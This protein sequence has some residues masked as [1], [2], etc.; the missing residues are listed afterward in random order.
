MKRSLKFGMG[1]LSCAIAA[2]VYAAT[3]LQFGAE[4]NV[5][6]TPT[7]TEKA[8]IVRLAYVDGGAFKKA[9]LFTYG[10]GPVGEQNVYA[11]YSF[12]DGATWSAPVL[13]SRDA[14]NAP[15]GG[16]TIVTRNSLAFVA[17]NDKPSIFAPPVTSGPT[18]G[19][20]LEQRLLPAGSAARATMPAATPTRRRVPAIS[21]ATARPTGPTTAYGWRRAPTR[22]WRPGTSSS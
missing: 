6:R 16:Q 8:K 5:S 20:H 18:G 14:A 13:L 22:H 3:A 12:D 11:R 19:R 17:D 15:T 4:V 2:A 10:D 1:A 9:W 7:P 21:T